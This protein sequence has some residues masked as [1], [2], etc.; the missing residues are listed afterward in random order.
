MLFASTASAQTTVS[1]VVRD[2]L[3]GGTLARATVQ[4]VSRNNAGAFERTAESD[5]L[6]RYLLKDIPIGRYAIGFFHPLLDSLGVEAPLREI[7]VD[8]NSPVVADVAVP[9]GARLRTAICGAADAS[10]AVIIGFVRDTR[11]QAPVPGA[12]ITGE[13]FEYMI[14]RGGLAPRLARQNATATE[15]GWFALCNVPT[16]GVVA[17]NAS[18]GADSTGLIEVQVPEDGFV[19]RELYVGPSTK[20]G[21]ISGVVF[22]ADANRPVA[23][24]QVSVKGGPEVRTN[25]QG[26]WTMT[27]V[28]TGTRMLEVRALGYYP[29]HRYVN[30][31][32][33]APPVRVTLST[34]RAVLDTVKIRAS[35]IYGLGDNG[36]EKRQRMGHGKFITAF[37][38]GRYPVVN[39]SDLLKRVP[40]V[41][42]DRDETGDMR[43]KMRGAFEPFCDPAIFIDG[44]FMHFLT[45]EDVDSWVPPHRV[46]GIEV[47]A[48]TVV[49][50]EFQVALRGCGSIVV[51][52]KK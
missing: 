20:S 26:Q 42:L 8:S 44:Q 7:N 4:L 38:I 51:W 45:M 37:D 30:V 31:V 41:R 16:G 34:L 52:T 9:S 27:G 19:R 6:G 33:S 17:L 50:P 23:N 1:G 32:E 14:R 40:G 35:R 18:R 49:P 13:W 5:S 24:A 12:V 29:D 36:F 28:P 21:R 25:D 2:S 10:G 39:T 11:N 47:Y 15:T 48:N 43:I 46:A 22:G 3:S